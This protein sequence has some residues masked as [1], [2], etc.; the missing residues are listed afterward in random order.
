MGVGKES[1]LG[2]ILVGNFAFDYFMDSFFKSMV[3]GVSAD[4]AYVAV[5]DDLSLVDWLGFLHS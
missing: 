4:N 1:R 2:S 5:K 3:V